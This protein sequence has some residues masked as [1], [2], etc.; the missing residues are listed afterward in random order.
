[1]A[2]HLVRGF[3]VGLTCSW[4]RC[5]GLGGEKVKEGTRRWGWV[6]QSSAGQ[7]HSALHPSTTA[8]F[9]LFPLPAQVGAKLLGCDVK[10]A[11][12]LLGKVVQGKTLSRWVGWGGRVGV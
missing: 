6:R 12:R 1:M 4:E 8:V 7:A 5:A 11:S 9:S 2:A 3:G 10:I